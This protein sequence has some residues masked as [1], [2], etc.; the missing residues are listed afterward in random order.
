MAHDY[1]DIYRQLLSAR[2]RP[3]P[4]RRI[5]NVIDHGQQITS[6]TSTHLFRHSEDKSPAGGRRAPASYRRLFVGPLDAEG[7]E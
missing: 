4:S 7:P 2:T 6:S 5:V 1:V 3:M